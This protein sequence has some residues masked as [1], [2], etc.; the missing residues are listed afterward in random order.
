MDIIDIGCSGLSDHRRVCE[1]DDDFGPDRSSAL[2]MK[3]FVKTNVENFGNPMGF[4]SA[5]MWKAGKK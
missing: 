3:I 4:Y 5:N 2:E 1:V